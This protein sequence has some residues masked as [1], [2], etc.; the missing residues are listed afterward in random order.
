MK[1]VL[2]VIVV[3]SA[4]LIGL[5]TWRIRAQQRAET[6]P[7]SGSGVVE[8]EGV[9]V[10]ARLSARVARV[11]VAEGQAV[12]SGATLIE[13]ECDEPR[14]RLLEANAR[15]ESARAQVLAAESSARASKGQSAAAMLSAS[16]LSAQLSALDTQQQ[17]ADRDAAR[18]E[19]MGDQAAA[20]ARDRARATALNLAEQKKAALASQSAG[21]NQALA[22]T[23]QASAAGVQI[24]VARANARALEQM[25]QSAEL[26]VKECTIVAPRSGVLERVYYDPGELVMLGAQVARVV[27][28]DLISV[29]FYLANAD[30]DQAR[31]GM[32]AFVNAD[33]YPDRR[34][35]GTI[36]RIGL[37]AEFTPR[38]VQTRSD[39][40]RLVY[41]VEVRVTTPEHQLRTGMQ[42]TVSLGAAP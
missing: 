39:R 40:D 2:V 27:D 8:A 32:K 38:N 16:A 31:V 22:S 33:A 24:E 30:V 29:T 42:A 36:H 4:A 18:L 21:K 23:A 11:L 26:V 15:L 41:P 1:R 13:L 35:D 17:L 7:P 14:T 25:V 9:D 12:K 3:L 6:A 37:T 20:A 5:I 19:G 34:F 28:P 10:S